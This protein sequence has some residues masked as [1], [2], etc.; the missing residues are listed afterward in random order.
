MMYWRTLDQYMIEVDKAFCGPN[1]PC[2]MN[3][4]GVHMFKSDPFSEVIFNKWNVET[5]SKPTVINF[6]GC[7]KDIIHQVNNLFLNNEVVLWDKRIVDFKWYEFSLFW[8][9]IENRFECSGLCSIAYQGPDSNPISNQPEQ[10][11]MYKYLFSDVNKGPVKNKGC[12]KH[13]LNSFPQLILAYGSLT[14]IASLFQIIG[15][16]F[17]LALIFK[18]LNQENKSVIIKL[19]INNINNRTNVNSERN[20]FNQI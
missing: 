7:P 4:N 3:V 19:D 14:L 16:I 20:Q 13:L 6:M 11:M 12:L 2:D 8:E 17:S 15:F 1:C 10:R 18:L 5:S 9:N